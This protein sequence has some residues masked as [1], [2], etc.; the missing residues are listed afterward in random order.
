VVK[1]ELIWG[2]LGNDGQRQ[3]RHDADTAQ[4]VALVQVLPNR[5][6]KF[7]AFPGKTGAD[8]NSFTSAARIYER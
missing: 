3:L 7:E 1:Y 6:L 8:V 5:K 2:Q 4:G